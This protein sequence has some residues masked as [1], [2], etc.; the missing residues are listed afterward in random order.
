MRFF[1]ICLSL[2]SVLSACAPENKILDPRVS[3]ESLLDLA[4]PEEVMEELGLPAENSV[5]TSSET[6]VGSEILT[7][8]LSLEDHNESAGLDL[9]QYF[10]VVL[11]INK[12]VRGPEAQTMTVYHRGM[13]AYRF[14]VSTGREREEL[15]KSGRRYFS[16]TPVGWFSP[17]R[18]YEKYFSKTWQ[19]PMNYSVFF[20]GGIATHATT[21]S[22]YKDLGKRASGGCVRLTEKNAK[23]I[24][25]LVLSEGHG[26]VPK[27][28][29]DGRIERSIFGRIKMHKS[30]NTLIIVEDEES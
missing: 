24:Y 10:P 19:A 6:E 5:E 16:R 14:A 7:T 3:S 22:Y 4:S 27:F 12:A 1:L 11:V 8:P 29:R 28:T 26:K 25:D 30:W 21:P 17:T 20:V 13:L 23:I 9:T 2:L 18:T 15:A